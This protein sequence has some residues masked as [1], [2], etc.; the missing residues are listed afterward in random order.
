MVPGPIWA[1]VLKEIA[2]NAEDFTS[3]PA[4]RNC[5]LTDAGKYTDRRQLQARYGRSYLC[6][7]G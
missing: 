3:K 6:S 4:C 5:P 1:D 7:S 2:L